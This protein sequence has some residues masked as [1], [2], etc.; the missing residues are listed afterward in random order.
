[1]FLYKGHRK[2]NLEV[3]EIV[4]T[5]VIKKN[6]EYIIEA[7]DLTHDGLG[8]GKIGG[9]T[10]FVKG[11]I[12]DET[13]KARITKVLK[14]YSYGRL[15]EIIKPS[16]YRIEPVCPVFDKC[17]G[18]QLQ[19]ISYEGQLDFKT[20]IVKDALERIG[21]F[22]DVKINEAMG[23]N[24]PW[25]YR[26]KAQYPVGM[27]NGVLSIGF[28]T[29]RSHE[30][31]NVENCLIQGKENDRIIKIIRE[32][33]KNHNIS[34]YDE[35]TGEGLI[36]HIMIRTGFK[37]GE[38]MICVVINGDDMPYIKELAETLRTKVEGLRSFILNTNK[39]KTNVVLGM[40][41]KIIYG[42][43]FICDH[44]G[45][46]KFKI[47]PQSFFQINPVMTEL[48][49]EKA[50]EYAGLGGGETVIDAYCGIG[51]ISLFLSQKAKKVY[52]I[53]IVKQAVLDAKEN[54][55]LNNVGNVEFLHGESET[56]I[57][58]LYEEGIK[59]DV[60]VVDPPRKGCDEKLLETIAEMSPERVVYISCNPATLARDLKYLSEWGYEVKEVQ[61]VDMFP[62][63]VH[64]ET[65]CLLTRI[66][67]M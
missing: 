48:L 59:A 27:K 20:K 18:C 45:K 57:P 11:A 62:W 56:V 31:V 60:I 37:T 43:G 44:I 13:A 1:M 9:F 63:T 51:T 3:I 64:V 8:V 32:F 4:N 54:A 25:N 5:A 10:V 61:P 49:Y 35:A 26:N 30:I 39:K 7:I 58:K 16:I 67:S 2:R 42:D 34:I 15:L 36:R 17:G 29:E 41:N 53:E 19:H 66:S 50:L 65:V 47:S 28:Y 55:G 22:T 38:I 33:I 40:E 21:G 14:N 23:M 6:Q 52:G 46:F 12:P 24:M